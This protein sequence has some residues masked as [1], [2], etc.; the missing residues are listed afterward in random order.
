VI[1][2]LVLVL[3][4]PLLAAGCMHASGGVAPSNVPLAPGSYNELGPVHGDD[5][6]YALLGILPLSGG[7]ETR[8]AV[9]EA[10]AAKPG[11]TALV[12]VSADTFHQF[13]ILLSRHCTEVHATAVRVGP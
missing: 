13:W 3:L 1:R 10:I 12:N 6:R 7:N 5:C 4:L 9:A 8:R 2:A 11:A